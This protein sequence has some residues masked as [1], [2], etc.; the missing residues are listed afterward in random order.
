MD[1]VNTK[2]RVRLHQHVQMARAKNLPIFPSLLENGQCQVNPLKIFVP[3][4]WCAGKPS[5]GV[6][7]VQRHRYH[8][9][10]LSVYP[11]PW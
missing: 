9:L 11:N 1:Y 7:H 4:L 2:I 10:S 8:V 5:L 6:Q 3:V